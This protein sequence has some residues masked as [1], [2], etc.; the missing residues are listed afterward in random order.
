MHGPYGRQM[1]I[2]AVDK[3]QRINTV[4]RFSFRFRHRLKMEAGHIGCASNMGKLFRCV[5]ALRACNWSW[6]LPG[7][8]LCTF[9]HRKKHG[10]VESVTKSSRKADGL[11]FGYD[12]IQRGGED[13]VKWGEN[14]TQGW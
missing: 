11:D 12:K 5:R 3:V 6:S 4:R 9:A 10:L 7:R 2:L 14:G 1:G 13:G 8:N